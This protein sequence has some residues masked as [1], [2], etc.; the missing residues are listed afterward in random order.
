M[1]GFL[2]DAISHTVHAAARGVVS[3]V[4]SGGMQDSVSYDGHAAARGAASAGASGGM[5]TNLIL[6][7]ASNRRDGKQALCRWHASHE[8]I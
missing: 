8:T 3:A 6:S 4:A 5:Q 7:A 2:V 1:A